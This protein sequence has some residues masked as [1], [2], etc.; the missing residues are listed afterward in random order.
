MHGH[1]NVKNIKNISRV[2][3]VNKG[4]AALTASLAVALTNF[5][6]KERKHYSV[7]KIHQEYVY[8]TWNGR[9][10]SGQGVVGCSTVLS[11]RWIS[12]FLIN[13][14][15]TSSALNVTS[16]LLLRPPTDKI[17]RSDVRK[18]VHH[19]TIQIIHQQDATVVGRGL[20]RPRPTTC[21]SNRF[22]PTVKPEA[23]SAVVCS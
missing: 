14:L 2:P 21:R 18:S 6:H 5:R 22:S 9:R 19:H 11:Y 8:Q 23:P 17:T 20:A 15:H 13:V 4:L 7:T 16:N 12:T 10:G 1:I 3:I